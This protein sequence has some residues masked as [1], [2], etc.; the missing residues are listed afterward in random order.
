[1]SKIGLQITTCQEGFRRGDPF[2]GDGS[3]EN[4]CIDIRTP[5]LLRYNYDDAAKEY[6][7]FMR[8]SK[9]GSYITIWKF[10][11]GSENDFTAFWL[12]I[13]SG[14]KIEGKEVLD[15]INKVK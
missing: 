1:M 10:H 9:Q 7:M 5:I 12:F 11:S 8:F 13:P 3:W 4:Q 15:L 6:G 14:I 2:N